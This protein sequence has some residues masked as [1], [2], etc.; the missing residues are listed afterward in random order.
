[1]NTNYSFNSFNS[2]LNNNCYNI[3]F[4]GDENVESLEAFREKYEDASFQWAQRDRLFLRSLKKR[5]K[6][7]ERN[8]KIIH[9]LREVQDEVRNFTR[10]FREEMKEFRRDIRRFDR[11]DESMRIGY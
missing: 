8:E 9:A 3:K 2:D 10:D 5:I 6:K 11:K 1:M 7:I 4:E